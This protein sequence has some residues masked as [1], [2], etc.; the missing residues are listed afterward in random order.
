MS[1]LQKFGEHLN[2]H[3][4]GL[5]DDVRHAREF[6]EGQWIFAFEFDDEV[7]GKPFQIGRF[8]TDWF[9]EP[10]N[11]SFDTLEEAI[12]YCDQYKG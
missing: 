8:G 7:T 1:N 11:P 6:K 9:Y 10:T 5:E 3:G 2:K 12:A 4:Y